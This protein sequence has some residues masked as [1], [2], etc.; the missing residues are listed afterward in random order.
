LE[1]HLTQNKG[2]L[3]GW[4]AHS[5]ECCKQ[6]LNGGIIA[7][8]FTS[9]REPVDVT[10][11]E[12]KTA[13]QLERVSSESEIVL[14]VSGG[15]GPGAGLGIVASQ[16]VKQVCALQFHGGI[17]FALLINEQGESDACF[18]AKS[19]RIGAIAKSYGCQGCAAVS[20]GLFVGAQLRDVLAAEDST[21][22]PQED[23]HCGL[24]DP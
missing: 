19:A 3:Q 14:R 11:P 23:H 6:G 16:Q 1:W 22:V 13:A 15:L 4:E 12:D 5:G 17:G 10:R 21:V 20:E 2:L 18:V 8:S 24:A 9:V 7:E